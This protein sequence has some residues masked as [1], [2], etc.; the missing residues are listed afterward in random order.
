MASKNAVAVRK[1]YEDLANR[2]VDAVLATYAPNFVVTDH[3]SGE[4]FKDLGE[5]RTW[6]DGFLTSST[7]ARITLDQVIDNGDTIVARIHFAGTNDGVFG[8]FPATGKQFWMDAC[9]VFEFDP[10]GMV[11]KEDAYYDQLNTLMQLGH[12]PAPE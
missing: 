1:G 10:D 11:I 9:E 12:I 2:D 8:P 7:D 3:A 4:S 5:V 6:I